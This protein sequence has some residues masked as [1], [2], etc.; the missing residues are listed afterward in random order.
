MIKHKEVMRV[1]I[2]HYVLIMIKR[3]MAN[4]PPNSLTPNEQEILEAKIGQQQ[5]K[6]E[7][8]GLPDQCIENTS[9]SI[10]HAMVK[11]SEAVLHRVD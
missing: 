6:D 4:P 8:Y 7:V 11:V 2:Y 5:Q 9:E 1:Q 10:P 3:R